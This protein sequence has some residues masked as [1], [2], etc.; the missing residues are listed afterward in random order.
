V[1]CGSCSKHSREQTAAAAA[2]DN[3]VSMQASK[4]CRYFHL[5][6]C[7][8]P[9]GSCSAQ[10]REAQ[11]NSRQHSQHAVEKC[12]GNS[13]WPSAWCPAAPAV[14]SSKQRTTQQQ[15]TQSA[16]RRA[17]CAHDLTLLTHSSASPQTR[18]QRC[19]TQAAR[20]TDDS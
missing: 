10:Q 7:L 20:K 9:C 3:T 8:V 15:A 2:A 1:P 13:T 12:A 14:Y 17:R 19:I 6:F 11:H 16:C 18:P 5:A 4:V